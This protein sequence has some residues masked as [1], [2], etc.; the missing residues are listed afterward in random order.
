MEKQSW[1]RLSSCGGW[2]LY[3]L[4]LIVHTAA[5]PRSAAAAAGVFATRLYG[6]NYSL[7]IGPDWAPDS[8]RCKSRSA[9]RTD[10]VQLQSQ[11]TN[12]VRIFSVTDCD[13]AATLLSL[14]QEL[15]MKIW[16]GLWVGPNQLNFDSERARLSELLNTTDF[17]NVLGI[18]VSSEAIYRHDITVAQAIAM[19]NLIKSD[20]DKVGLKN[21]PVTVADVID[22]Y[23]YNANLVQVDPLAITFNQFPFWEHASNTAIAAQNMADKVRQLENQAG[24][25]QIIVTETGWADAGF[26]AKAGVADPANMAQ[27]MRDFVCL[28][29][30]RKWQYFWF[31]AYDSDWER[32]N[33]QLPNDVEGH[34]GMFIFLSAS[35]LFSV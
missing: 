34:F 2:F 1:W 9:A 16:L 14:T 18:H 24:G 31:I 33:D 35:L 5:V 6:V 20:L 32:A 30:E 28:A 27:W 21:I 17:G 12:N 7:R 15:H 3:V 11:I 23:L 8:A 13:A 19:R 22:T 25:R 29:N 26:N 4:L 10:L